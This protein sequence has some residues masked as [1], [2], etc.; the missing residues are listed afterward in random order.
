MNT[1]EVLL[2]I[3]AL[4]AG[5]ALYALIFASPQ[6]PTGSVVRVGEYQATTTST[7][8]FA[9]IALVQSGAS[10]LGSVVITGA[11][12]GVINIYDATTT[13]ITLRAGS[14]ATSTITKVELPA[15]TV[16]GTYTFDISLHDG[17]L[18]ETIGT[19]P[20][21]TITFR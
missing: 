1:K 16:A 5:A 20:T 13:D 11:A 17:L 3:G 14:K 9:T 21:T 15:S 10:T 12:A 6:A 4:I 8:N 19:S 7:G 2:S 18:V